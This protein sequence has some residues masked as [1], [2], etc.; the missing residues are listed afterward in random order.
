MLDTELSRGPPFWKLHPVQ[1]H[2]DTY[3][4]FHAQK[5]ANLKN[6][7]CNQSS[8]EH[9]DVSVWT[10]GVRRDLQLIYRKSF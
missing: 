7:S 8:H 9:P 2:F 6:S 4:F 3:Y 5:V 1:K 10:A